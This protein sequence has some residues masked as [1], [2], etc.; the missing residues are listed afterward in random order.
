MNMV[1]VLRDLFQMTYFIKL[2][3]FILYVGNLGAAAIA[4]CYYY[5]AISRPD[6]SILSHLI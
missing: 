5:L 6:L 2:H 3:G 4:N 1:I